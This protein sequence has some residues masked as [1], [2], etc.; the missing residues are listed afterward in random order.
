MNKD[1]G[2][3]EKNR[4]EGRKHW[5][6]ALKTFISCVFGKFNRNVKNWIES[7]SSKLS[8]KMNVFVLEMVAPQTA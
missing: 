6:L 2:M 7:L 5:E 8:G 4:G 1:E 3:A